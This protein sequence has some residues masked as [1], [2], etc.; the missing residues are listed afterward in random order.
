[1]FDSDQLWSPKFRIEPTSPVA[2][3]GSCFAQHIGKTLEQRGFHWLVTERRP[4]GLSDN[5]SKTFNYEVFS[6]RTGNIYTASLLKQWVRW[7]L[8]ISRPPEEYW[9]AS[10]SYFD[11][12]RPA[13]EPGGFESVDELLQSRAATIDAFRESI[14]KSKYFVFT[15][16]LT[17]SW[18]DTRHGYEYPMCP[19]TVAGVF[20]LSAHKFVN[21]HFAMI[22]DSLAE[23]IRLMRGINKNLC[24]IFTVSPVPLTAT[25]S[26][27]HVVVATMYSK[28][29]LRA[30]AGQM[31]DNNVLIDYFPSYEIINSPVFRGSFFEPNQ[32]NVTSH[33]VNFVMGHF[34]RCLATKFGAYPTPRPHV[35]MAQKKIDEVCEE[36]L[37][38][39]FGGRK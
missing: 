26:G 11:P 10:G 15:L 23:S 9:E 5:S 2:T 8:N 24:F 13:V 35:Q 36:E 21:Q 29:V 38:A 17:E 16:G 6:S 22:R 1:M 4:Y 28:S 3:Y 34:F 31:A 25:N 14:E 20:D 30:V 39:V 19:G 37:L 27:N 32:R 7:A 18:F 12:F 33:G